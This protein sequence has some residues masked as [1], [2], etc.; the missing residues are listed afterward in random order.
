MKQMKELGDILSC[1]W[2]ISSY[3]IR[4]TGLQ[5]CLF[6]VAYV[7]WV[8]SFTKESVLHRK[9][10]CVNTSATAQFLC[11]WEIRSGDKVRLP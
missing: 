5:K 8:Y 11:T 1:V 3:L 6:M 9:G 10:T 7:F 2:G 4:I